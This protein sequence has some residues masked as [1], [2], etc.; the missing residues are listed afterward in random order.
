M[1][2]GEHDCIVAVSQTAVRQILQ[3][4]PVQVIVCCRSTRSI[5]M[6]TT[7]ENDCIIGANSLMKGAFYNNVVIASGPV[8][9]FCM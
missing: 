6:D 5:L 7:I 3:G 8:K 4:C 2:I 1:S 9:V